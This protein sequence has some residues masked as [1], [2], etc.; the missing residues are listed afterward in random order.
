M[1]RMDPGE[2]ADLA[3]R[4]DRADTTQHTAEQV[5]EHARAALGA[6]HGGITL[7]RGG[8]R[9][10]TIAPSDGLVVKADLLQ[11][12]LDEGPCRDASW[13]GDNALASQDLAADP[14]WPQWA[15]QAHH[16]GIASVLAAEL[17]AADT[18]KRLGALNLYWTEP[19]RFTSDDLAYISIFAVHA[20]VAL[21][22]SMQN[23]QLNTA[24]DARKVIGQAQGILMERHNLSAEQA[25]EVLRRYS[26]DHNLKLRKVAEQLVATR[27]LPRH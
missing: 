19:A 6:D 5:V 17:S 18:S 25:F 16:L 11:Y 23:A 2:F 10:E 22:A 24:L 27:Q 20:A 15:P 21:A 9:L 12:D 14:R 8:G 3:Q 1:G 26:Q 7:I 4:L 13:N